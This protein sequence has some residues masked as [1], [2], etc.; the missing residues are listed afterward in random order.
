M[1]HQ[2]YHVTNVAC[3]HRHTDWLST[4]VCVQADD[5]LQAFPR[6]VYPI[7]TENAGGIFLGID[8]FSEKCEKV[9]VT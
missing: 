6:Y 3:R 7:V 9:D 8:G 5:R 4:G 1:S 2:E